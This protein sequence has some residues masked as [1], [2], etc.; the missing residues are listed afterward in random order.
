[1]T[2]LA[3]G[4]ADFA[5]LLAAGRVQGRAA[6]EGGIA[7][8]P[9]LDMLRGV[10]ARVRPH[11]DPAAWWIVDADE[12]VGLCSIVSEP[13]GD[14]SI[15]I[16]YGVASSRQGRG[17]A[18]RAVGEVLEWAGTRP[19]LTGVTAET[20]VDNPASHRVLERNG[21][22]R[23]GVRTDAEDGELIGWRCVVAR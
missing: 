19:D 4:D 9:V 14:G 7:P 8:D 15:S 22:V 23:V 21:F 3:A 1:M 12:I 6:A 20:A 13:S 2:I 5:D 11:C 16:G 10:A 17:A 18:T